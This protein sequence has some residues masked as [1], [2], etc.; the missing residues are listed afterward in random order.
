M[1]AKITK[2][3]GW[4]IGTLGLGLVTALVIPVYLVV[5]LLVLPAVLLLETKR[6]DDEENN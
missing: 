2:T 6:Y 3:I 5:A 1:G 4:I